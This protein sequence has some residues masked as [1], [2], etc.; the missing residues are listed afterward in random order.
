MPRMMMLALL[1][2]QG[3]QM[4]SVMNQVF[5]LLDENNY[6]LKPM[7]EQEVFSILK[8]W[9]NEVDDAMR[10]GMTKKEFAAYLIFDAL[11]SRLSSGSHH[12]YKGVLSVNG[13]TL[14]QQALKT[15]KLLLQ[16]NLVHPDKAGVLLE[17]IQEAVSKSG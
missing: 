10:E 5:L 13:K 11:K 12:V 16:M 2:V 4:S 1:R 9:R 8:H 7:I 14:S 3:R 17:D 6:S 15:V